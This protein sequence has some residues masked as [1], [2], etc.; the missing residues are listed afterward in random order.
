MIALALTFLRYAWPFIVGALLWYWADDHWCN[1]ACQ[2]AKE[3]TAKQEARAVVAEDKLAELDRQRIAQQERWAAATKA[4]QELL[5]AQDAKRKQVFAGLK[6]RSRHS[7]FG[8]TTP[9][10]APVK[11]MLGDAYAAASAAE[12]ASEPTAAAPADSE[13]VADL[14]TWSVDILDWAGQ[15]KATVEGWQRWYTEISK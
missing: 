8:R 15:C 4:E 7:D 14:I 6:D 13:T 9:V 10:T 5:E 12:A 1:G 3:D 2:A 11:R